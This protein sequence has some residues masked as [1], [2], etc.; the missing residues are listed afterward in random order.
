MP[1]IEPNK[2]SRPSPSK[3]RKPVSRFG[4]FGLRINILSCFFAIGLFYA[5][6]IK[7]E[8]F[9]LAGFAGFLIPPLILVHF[10]FLGYWLYR[11]PVFGI[12]SFFTL[13]LGS[14]F[15]LATFGWHLLQIEPCK[16][17]KVLSFNAKSFGGMNPQGKRDDADS[18]R[19]ISQIVKSD[20]QIICIQ[21][22]FDLP[23]SKNFNVVDQLKKKGFRYVYFSKARTFKWG[24][25][26]G[27]AIFSKYPILTKLALRKK[28]GSN[29]QIIRAKIDV[30]GQ[31]LVII[32]MHLQ[33][34]FIKEDEI[35]GNQIKDD[36]WKSV[37]T[38]TKKLRVANKARTR[39]ID[40][41]LASTLDEELPVIICGD[42]NDTPYSNSYV[43]LR[44][45]FQNGFEEKGAGFG[46][47]Y[48][49][50]IPFLRID[51]QFANN[52]LRFTRFKTRKDLQGSDHFGTEACYQFV[53][54]E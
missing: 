32:N 19:L 42:M 45:S 50:K 6:T 29:N 2:E 48:N 30:D 16:Q 43:R 27:M 18:E 8:S 17:F 10:L 20:A 52:R 36:F 33:S 40:L 34:F 53:S 5:C 9:W 38:L 7:P 46:I 51:N 15:I 11:K 14:R 54:Q 21:E 37:T 4:L 3:R 25:S 24:A 41:L 31:N 47:T 23:K 28:E 44:D 13:M 26:V 39:Q 35:D 49:G 12:F 1:R 22:M